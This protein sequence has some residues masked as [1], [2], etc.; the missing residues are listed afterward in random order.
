MMQIGHI[1]H[2]DMTWTEDVDSRRTWYHPTV[3]LAHG[4]VP[5]MAL[6]RGSDVHCLPMI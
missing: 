6:N 2:E 4:F 5:A 1:F 3:P